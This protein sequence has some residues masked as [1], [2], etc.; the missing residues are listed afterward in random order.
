MSFSF[1]PLEDH[2]LVASAS[3]KSAHS[4]S[5]NTLNGEAGQQD[6]ADR[7][8][9]VQLEN[10][11]VREAGQLAMV[12]L[13][14]RKSM[15]VE[16]NYPK[17]QSI[18]DAQGEEYG[19]GTKHK[20]RLKVSSTT[21]NRVEK[22]KSMMNLYY[23]CL[24]QSQQVTEPKYPLVDGIYN[25]LQIIRNRKLRSKYNEFPKLSF[26]ILP[27]ASTVFSK[28]R[29]PFKWEV[30]L[31]E[32]AYDLSWRSNH[33]HELVNA[34]GEVWYPLASADST[35]HRHRHHHHHQH[36]RK[37]S[38]EAA[39]IHDKLF[40]DA[41]ARSRS[42]SPIRKLHSRFSKSRDSIELPT[43]P[44]PSLQ[45]P[46]SPPLL[47]V[48]AVDNDGLTKDY[49]AGIVISPTKKPQDTTADATSIPPDT[50]AAPH[51]LTINSTQ[52]LD[53]Q[54]LQRLMQEDRQLEEFINELI[55][56]Q[57]LIDFS[58][59][60][61]CIKDEEL[62][63]KIQF[64]RILDKINEFN[65]TRQGLLDQ[66]FPKFNSSVVKKSIELED[67]QNT[68]LNEY[69]PKIDQLLLLS[70]R[71]IGEVNTT[72]SLQIRK[73]NERLEKLQPIHKRSGWIINFGYWLLENLVVLLFWG[74][75][76]G[77]S[78]GKCF[79]CLL[80]VVWRIVCWLFS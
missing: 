65:A 11:K 14:L 47:T 56:L 9:E 72:L 4:S 73:L 66:T 34:N 55:E 13:E 24:F 45:A 41:R 27:Y 50:E 76:I 3:T 79:R 77:F 51:P 17:P 16:L 36:R 64:S 44:S 39:R 48:T 52:L 8:H 20:R 59:Y 2:S 22:V 63:R 74:V 7:A 53:E 31:P 42:K 75:W 46:A 23:F 49:L 67:F 26:K 71:T 18:Q 58:Q 70:D 5:S 10:E 29:H 61:F 68:L 54:D 35:P 57:T 78:I 15:M 69:S 38:Q 37:P 25:P 62:S 1:D 21:L 28:N 40:D 80:L 43:I 19:S 12:L 60:H 32:L 30:E 33:W 6:G